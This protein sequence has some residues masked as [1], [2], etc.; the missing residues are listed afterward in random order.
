MTEAR[1]K[2]PSIIFL[3]ELDSIGDREK[4]NK[5][6]ANYSTQV[7]NGL[8]ECIDGSAGR[9]GIVVIGATNNAARI[10]AAV[11]RAGRLDKHIV[12]P[13]PN[14]EDRVAILQHHLGCKLE[15]SVMGPLGPMTEGMTGA[16]LGQLVRDARRTARR[17]RR[18]V[19]VADLTAHLPE[20]I[21]IA[22]FYRQSIAIHEAGHAIVG[23][24]LGHGELQGIIIQR[25]LNPRARRQ[26]VGQALFKRKVVG[27]RDQQTYLDEVC[28]SMA[29]IAAEKLVL[30]RHGDGAGGGQG[31]DL[32]RATETAILMESC[33]GMGDRLRFVDTPDGE[34]LTN[35][36]V[37][38]TA[39]AEK[40]DQVLQQ[41]LARA[42]DILSSHRLLL[43]RLANEL[44]D[45][46]VVTPGR[47]VELQQE[48]SGTT[49]AVRLTKP[50]RKRSK[51]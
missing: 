45:E 12:I 29:G 39:L 47:F 30:N 31:S 3:D 23:S 9:E 48:V 32:A 20:L 13:M 34:S 10:D 14:D 38:D 28:T 5:D 51:G 16:D 17:E 43:D 26:N 24:M 35:L 46:G 22:G 27:F 4:F 8:L 40:V 36:G 11:T 50:R 37:L 18:D 49:P 15:L 41:E 6:H 1:E 33:F 25:Q 2:A 21:P 44:V 7:V 19:T 42:V